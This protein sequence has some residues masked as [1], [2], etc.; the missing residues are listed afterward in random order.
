M[1]A[2]EKIK[3]AKCIIFRDS[4]FFSVLMKNIKIQ[5]VADT[6]TAYIY[7]NTIGYNKTFFEKISTPEI[8]G[9]LCHEVMHKTLRHFERK[10]NRDHKIWNMAT[11]YSINAIVKE[12]FRLPEGLLYDTRFE[13]MNAEV[14]YQE[15]A[16]NPT[17]QKSQS[18]GEHKESILPESL[19]EKR[20]WEKTIK[21]ASHMQQQHQKRQKNFSNISSNLNQFIQGIEK[22]IIDWKQL[23]IDFLTY[24]END[25]TYTDPDHTFEDDIDGGFLLPDS[26]FKEELTNVVI[27]IDTSGSMISDLDRIIREIENLLKTMEIN[28]LYYSMVDTEVQYFDLIKKVPKEVL[29]HGGTCFHPIFNLLKEKE[30][31]PKVLIYLTDGYGS[32]PPNPPEFPVIWLTESDSKVK[33]P[34]GVVGHYK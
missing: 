2:S 32:F 29:G 21:Q 33:F 28:N 8:A 10:Q 4:P 24:E 9:V 1:E 25:Y 34:F 7:R 19:K 14:I 17:L 27:T 15:L 22:N 23:L 31:T 12:R 30:I 13:K 11:D 26:E 16:Q 20:E 6:N 18:W 3:Y 5:E